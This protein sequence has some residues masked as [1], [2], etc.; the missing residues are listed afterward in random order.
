MMNKKAITIS[1]YF[2][3]QG[4]KILQRVMSTAEFLKIEFMQNGFFSYIVFYHFLS[5]FCGLVER[6]GKL[7]AVR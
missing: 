2:F 6:I 4:I 1:K 5:N 3:K 7:G